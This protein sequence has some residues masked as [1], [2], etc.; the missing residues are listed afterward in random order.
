M[1]SGEIRGMIKNNGIVLQKAIPKELFQSIQMLFSI[2]GAPHIHWLVLMTTQF[3]Y[4][5]LIKI[6]ENYSP[7]FMYI[8][9]EIK[10]H[11][12]LCVIDCVILMLTK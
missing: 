2:Y 9:L 11:A 5:K 1:V 10:R 4:M 8:L 12:S 6:I 3:R 7:V